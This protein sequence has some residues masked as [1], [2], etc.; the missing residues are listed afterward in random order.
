MAREQGAWWA[1]PAHWICGMQSSCSTQVEMVHFFWTKAAWRNEAGFLHSSENRKDWIWK[2][3]CLLWLAK[4]ALS[5]SVLR[6][7]E[8]KY[9]DVNVY[10]GSCPSALQEPRSNLADP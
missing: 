5:T 7:G 9:V 8:A 2:P 3:L 6:F 4:I 10:S 1:R